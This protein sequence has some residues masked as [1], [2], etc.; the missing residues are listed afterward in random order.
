MRSW[1]AR[2]RGMPGASPAPYGTSRNSPDSL[3]SLSRRPP[4]VEASM[5]SQMDK[6]KRDKS[7]L[8]ATIRAMVALDLP[9][10][11]TD[12]HPDG[13]RRIL[14]IYRNILTEAATALEEEAAHVEAKS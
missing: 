4:K 14:Q 8:A 9:D 12:F 1:S 6:P 3:H 2:R 7:Q 11:D 5:L 13:V 10:D